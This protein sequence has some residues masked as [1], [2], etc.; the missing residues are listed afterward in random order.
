MAGDTEIGS[1]T[2]GVVPD[3]SGIE[4]KL[5]DQI[6]PGAERVGEEAGTE[7][8][9]AIEDKMAAG[10]DK[11]A[12]RFETSFKTR[13][14]K[15]LDSLPEA[16]ID[17]DISDVER[18]LAEIRL[19]IEAIHDAPLVDKAQTAASLDSIMLKVAAIKDEASGID[20]NISDQAKNALNDLET[21]LAK[22]RGKAITGAL[23]PGGMF[24]RIPFGA[25][26][27]ITV[28]AAQPEVVQHAVEVAGESMDDIFNEF[29]ALQ[30]ARDRA[31]EPAIRR[32]SFANIP[33]VAGE[34]IGDISGMTSPARAKMFAAGPGGIADI[35]QGVIR[36]AMPVTP[37]GGAEFVAGVNGVE[38]AAFS[39]S[40][41]VELFRKPVGD[42][43]RYSE[44]L[45]GYSKEL[46]RL[47]KSAVTTTAQDIVKG[48][49]FSSK[50]FSFIAKGLGIGQP[51]GLLGTWTGRT[52]GAVSAVGG[53][54][55]T[56]ALN[57]GRYLV[58]GISGVTG[59]TSA[60]LSAMEKAAEVSGVKSQTAKIVNK[61]LTQIMGSWIKGVLTSA[62]K[63]PKTLFGAGDLAKIEARLKSGVPLSGEL[64]K[65]ATFI[66]NMQKQKKDV[67]NIGDLLLQFGEGGGSIGGVLTGAGVAPEGAGAGGG[68]AGLLS[69]AAPWV[70]GGIAA[71]APFIAQ[72]ISGAVISGLGI[73]M[74][75]FSFAGALQNAGIKKEFT[76][77]GKQFSGIL[78]QSGEQFVPVIQSVL[79]NLSTTL[80]VLQPF[81]SAAS[82]IISIPMQ[83]FLDTI[84]TSLATPQVQHA[85]EAIAIAFGDILTAI[86][87]DVAG[88]MESMA[89]SVSRI[90]ASVAG[91]P[92]AFA[93]FVNFLFEVGIAILNV[94]AGLSDFANFLEQGKFG[95]NIAAINRFFYQL[96]DPN[97][98]LNKG[99]PKVFATIK[100]N[101]TI[102]FRDIGGFFEGIGKG[103]NSWVMTGFNQELSS[104]QKNMWDIGKD[105]VNGVWHGIDLGISAGGKWVYDHFVKPFVDFFTSMQ[106]GFGTASPSKRMIPIGIDIV[107]G[108][109][110]GM[111]S[112]WNST[113]V[114][115]FTNLP[116]TLNRYFHDAI[117][118]LWNAGWN[119]ASGIGT[120]I[121]SFLSTIDSS[122]V[123]THIF[124]PL[125]KAVFSYFGMGSPAKKTQPWGANIIT[126]IVQG[127]VAEGKN[128]QK[129]AA[130]IF[131][132]W[133]KAI[134]A[135]FSKSTGI[136]L[137]KIP[138]SSR[139]LLQSILGS[140]AAV[141][142]ALG[143][144]GRKAWA[145]ISSGS[146]GVAQW[147]STVSKALSILKLPQS[148]TGQVLYQIQT[149]SGG[150]PNAINLTDINAKR[151]D[152]SRGLLQTIGATFSQY[153]VPGT[154]FN[155]Y[156]PLANIAAAINYAEHRYGPS[157]MRGG[158]GLGSGHGYDTGGWLPTGVTM[159]INNTGKPELVLTADQA[160]ALGGPEYHAHFDGLTSQAIQ[161]EVRTAFHMMSLTQGYLGRPGRRS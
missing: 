21:N 56:A 139:A 35:I 42:I 148:L 10:G 82:A 51:T 68:G 11:S 65:F 107:S 1:V 146:G 31:V 124:Q 13:L 29:R 61:T 106:Y 25:T 157:L 28:A 77:I 99:D 128:I 59:P 86:T 32:P 92:K 85:I 41:E 16:K 115:W 94:V 4:Q 55:G 75:G 140:V 58:G 103:I 44:S 113:I 84:V 70:I 43:V 20:V 112:F 131:G 33:L 134:A 144:A 130:K 158:M 8:S 89:D 105:I 5:R 129:F 110:Q 116:S 90:A 79:D 127:M 117:N 159:A 71:A 66:K 153:H 142:N 152:P 24:S 98:P 30:A 102:T 9:D 100:K 114:P 104:L 40:K 143:A 80:K 154:S 64:S 121:Q 17:G 22:I 118:W 78:G 69:G 91:N 109:W 122:W 135:V 45:G 126:G 60:E 123:G 26:P 38:K 50:F 12:T 160:S 111:T 72:V 6:V 47:E 150:N 151:G 141:P 97:S 145:W 161:A 74:A 138:A 62:D 37:F 133:D 14:K 2:V 48:A 88:G 18:K 119:I 156:D 73:G 53:A 96:F 49:G 132:G 136:N 39:M 155:I 15:A 147:A 3:A 137:S 101:I 7:M 46:V 63:M 120:G 52:G 36:E 125:K 27:K 23:V 54:A 34:T 93:D 83:K 67:S 76:S 108:L 95:Q 81:F 149:E 87:P 57:V 19:E